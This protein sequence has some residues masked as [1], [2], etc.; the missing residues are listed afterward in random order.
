MARM[1][2][3]CGPIQAEPYSS[4]AIQL[5]RQVLDLCDKLDECEAQE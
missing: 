4:W 2:Q 5:A 1:D 3:D